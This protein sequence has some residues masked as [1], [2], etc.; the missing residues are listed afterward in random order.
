MLVYSTTIVAITSGNMPSGVGVI[1]LSGP[2]SKTILEAC[3]KQKNQTSFEP[4]RMYFGHIYDHHE[5]Y[6]IDDV[7]MVWMP[8]PQSFTGEDVVE[9]Y[10]HGSP[11]ILQ[12]IVDLCCSYG[13]EVAAPGEFTQRA[14]LNGKMDLT[15]AESVAEIIHAES[16]ESLKWSQKR[17]SGHLKRKILSIYSSITD[18]LAE[19]EADIDFPDENLP[20]SEKKDLLEKIE[21]VKTELNSLL[22]SYVSVQKVRE[23]YKVLFFGP[24]N[25]GKSSLFN[26]LLHQNRA[27]VSDIAGTTRDSIHEKITLSGYL[28][29]LMDVAGVRCSVGDDIEDQGIQRAWDLAEEADLI[30]VLLPAD[31]PEKDQTHFEKLVGELTQIYPEK[32]LLYCFSKSDLGRLNIHLNEKLSIDCSAK[33]EAGLIELKQYFVNQ[34]QEKYSSGHAFGG[35]QNDRQKN[36]LQTITQYFE[37]GVNEWTN[38]LQ[39]EL[40]AQ[41]FRDALTVLGE[42]LGK[43]DI[44]EDVLDSI[45]SKFCVGK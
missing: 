19:C 45:F 42:I 26:A 27:I 16:E 22:S 9:I 28:V 24:P 8:G 35:V 17:L 1:R 34:I 32:D 4:R 41:Y 33:T 30:C 36:L 12:K 18:I 7:L 40:S 39:V 20:L 6:K 29:Q 11:L 15:Q 38:A 23:G 25:A 44:H 13:A 14:Y 31:L 21:D 2:K 10:P 5:N 43:T 37:Q 3:L